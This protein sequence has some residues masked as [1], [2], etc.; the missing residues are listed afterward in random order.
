MRSKTTWKWSVLFF[1]LAFGLQ[2]MLKSATNVH[3]APNITTIQQIEQ[4][5]N[6]FKLVKGIK[7]YRGTTQDWR[8]RLDA[9]RLSLRRIKP[10][11][12]CEFLA[13]QGKHWQKRSLKTR[14]LFEKWYK[15][16]YSKYECIHNHEASWFGDDNPT[17]DGGLQM[18]L[19]FQRTYGGEFLKKWGNASHWPIWSQ[20]RAA[21]RA[22][23]G[24]GRFKARYFYPW[25]T[26]AYC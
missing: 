1:V 22:Y 10:S 14:N 9:P 21:E 25:P 26:A 11:H 6:K 2:L 7:F 18:D 20:L 4:T 5:C 3:A 15:Q 19:G 23:Y 17:Y 13:W 8:W 12:S 24:Y 16:T